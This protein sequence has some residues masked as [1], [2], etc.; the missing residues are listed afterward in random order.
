MLLSNTG[1][2]T[3]I[4]VVRLELVYYNELAEDVRFEAGNNT[5]SPGSA[6]PQDIGLV[7]TASRS[8]N[9]EFLFITKRW[10]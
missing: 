4:I 5:A 7:S 6:E 8:K 9:E 2:V 1:E 3:R 10:E